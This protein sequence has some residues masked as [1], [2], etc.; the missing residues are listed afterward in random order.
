MTA[1]NLKMFA[2]IVALTIIGIA[3]LIII[4]IVD[5]SVEYYQRREE[6]KLAAPTMAEKEADVADPW[7]LDLGN[8]CLYVLN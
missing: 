8:L 6:T 7:I 3:L 5:Y 2:G 4:P 1:I